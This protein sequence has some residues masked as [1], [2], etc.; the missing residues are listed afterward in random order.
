[1]LLLEFFR[2]LQSVFL[3][4]QP[5]VVHDV[6]KVRDVVDYGLFIFEGMFFDCVRVPFA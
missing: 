2:A 1:V 5:P 6:G 3:E 4:V